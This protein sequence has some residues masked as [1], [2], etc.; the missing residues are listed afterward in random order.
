MCYSPRMRLIGRVGTVAFF[1]MVAGCTAAGTDEAETA[2]ASVVSVERLDTVTPTE[3]GTASTTRFESKMATL[4][5]A[6]PETKQVSRKTVDDFVATNVS[7][8]ESERDREISETIQALFAFN[9]RDELSLEELK[10]SF[11]P[12]LAGQLP[13]A[14]VA[15][16][17]FECGL[18]SAMLVR[19]ACFEAADA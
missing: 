5:A 11:G 18:A 15:S 4:E 13:A 17:N 9:E 10:T 3:I 1:G 12:W 6:H 14:T 2:S 8:F 19:A 16:G 7:E